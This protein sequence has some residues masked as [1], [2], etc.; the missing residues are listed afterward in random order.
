MLFRTKIR[1]VLLSAV[2]LLVYIVGLSTFGDA[3]RIASSS[4]EKRDGP[5]K[6]KEKAEKPRSQKPNVTA[7][8]WDGRPSGVDPKYHESARF[9]KNASQRDSAVQSTCCSL[10]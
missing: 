2:G 1:T 3:F 8:F 6:L 9:F 10:F 7:D 4:M 5:A